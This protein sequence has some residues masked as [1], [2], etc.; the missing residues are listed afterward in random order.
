MRFCTG[1]IVEMKVRKTDDEK[2]VRECDLVSDFAIASSSIALP[3]RSILYSLV[4][5]RA[6]IGFCARKFCKN[7][8]R[9]RFLILRIHGSYLSFS[10]MRLPQV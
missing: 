9:V 2:D 5:A 7:H 3:T 8:L 6:R 4:I 10:R 1:E